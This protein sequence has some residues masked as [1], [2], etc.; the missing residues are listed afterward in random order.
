MSTSSDMGREMYSCDQTMYIPC[1]TIT[2]A[3]I[4]LGTAAFTTIDP[5]IAA[6]FVAANTLTS[7]LLGNNS[8]SLSNEASASLRLAKVALSFFI[9]LAAL[10]VIAPSIG[11]TVTANTA[12]LLGIIVVVSAVAGEA[13]CLLS[14]LALFGIFALSTVFEFSTGALNFLGSWYTEGQPS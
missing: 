10:A 2:R 9:N 11:F 12:A 5:F 7:A 4:S 14:E 1:Q 8:S 3:S 6:G 13:I